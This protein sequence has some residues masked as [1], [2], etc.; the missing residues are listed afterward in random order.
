MSLAFIACV[1]RG[2]LEDET[3]LLCRSIR[4]YAGRYRDVAIYTF[5]PRRGM[6]I[7]ANTLSVLHELG[8]THITE[9]LN[10]EFDDYAIG[11]KIFTCA[12]AEE[13]LTE[14]ILVFLD[15]DTVI[16]SEPGELELPREFE[17]AVRP[18]NR[19][20]GGISS[21][22]PGDANEAYWER[23]YHACSQTTE[24]FVETVVDRRQ[25]RA[26]FSA[27]IIAVRRRAGLWGEW[28]RHFEKLMAAGLVPD[29]KRRVRQM[30][31]ISLA[32]TLSRNFECVRILDGRYN[33]LI[34]R[35]SELCSPYREAQLED[36]VHIHY[37]SK[38]SI[39]EYLRQALPPFDQ[40][41]EIL[42]WLEQYI[43]FP[44]GHHRS[45]R[46]WLTGEQADVLKEVPG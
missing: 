25:V 43:P 7:S 12:W 37:I 15:S 33:Y 21:A 27:G 22:G 31:E 1:E 36:L 30:D 11:N 2:Y 38:F 8:V 16:V 45:T 23:L 44:A 5:Q 35:R 6:E 19:W 39:P 14:D 24:P 18:C 28:K 42:E 20:E 17:C 9:T 4:R 32:L 29:D 10:T 41:S 13:H 34:Y 40:S 26:Y 46:T 3:K